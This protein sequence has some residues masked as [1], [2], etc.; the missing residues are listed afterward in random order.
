MILNNANFVTFWDSEPF[1]KGALIAMEG[2]TIV[3]FGSVG[4]LADRYDDADTLDV[5]GRIVMPGLINAHTHLRRTLT[6]GMPIKGA[7]P[8]TFQEMQEALWWR[9]DRALSEEDV[10]LGTMVGLLDS[11]RAGVTTVI[12]HHSSPAVVPGCLDVVWQAFDEVG[13]RGS[14][15]YG[16]SDRFGSRVSQAGIDENRRFIQRC[17]AKGSEMMSGLF[18]L[19]ACSALSGQTVERAVAAHSEAGSD[20]G[21]HV[22]VAEDRGDLETTRREHG[23]TPV[24]RLVAAGVLNKASLAVHCVH[25]EE[26]DFRQLKASGARV[27]VCPQSNV[28][29]GVDGDGTADL[30]GL[31]GTGV[32][33]AL[34]TDGVTASVF[35]EFRAAA[36]I[37][38]VRGRPSSGAKR[39]AFKAAF[40]GNG[41]LATELFG[42]TLGKIKPGA[43]ADLVVLDHQP[44]TPLRVE[45]FADH[46]FLGMSR[47]PVYAVVINGRLVFKQCAFPYLD[48]SGIRARARRAADALWKRM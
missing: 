28:A 45:N 37:E 9:P 43:R 14:L 36:L 4:K 30:T 24:A 21:F 13:V 6:R 31:R 29:S 12:D 33:T 48:E 34:G 25:L 42:A 18:G 23:A 3:D 46:F 8:R 35:E 26:T 27:V 41:L 15:S 19:D 39:E 11:V 40:L 2:K 22:H 32:P 5:G 17:K 20:C 47:A 38:R 1:V 44:A 10:Y 7:Q 16:V